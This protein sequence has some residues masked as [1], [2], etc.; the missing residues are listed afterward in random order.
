MSQATVPIIDAD[1]HVDADLGCL[2]HTDCND[3]NPC[4]IDTCSEAG[5]C[6]NA[7]RPAGASCTTGVCDGAAVEPECVQC[8]DNND[9]PFPDA[10]CSFDEPICTGGASPVCVEC[11]VPGHCT[12]SGQ[13]SEASCS[14]N[15]CEYTSLELG[16]LC[17][18][19]VCDG[20]PTSPEC[21]NCVD[22]D[23]GGGIDAGCTA[24]AR[25]C[26]DTLPAPLCRTCGP[27]ALIDDAATPP[28]SEYYDEPVLLIEGGGAVNPADP[29]YRRTLPSWLNWPVD[30]ALPEV[31]RRDLEWGA[32]NLFVQNVYANN[33][34][35]PVDVVSLTSLT[36]A[37]ADLETAP[38][39]FAGLEQA[40]LDAIAD[41]EDWSG[42]TTE[43]GVAI[44]F[45]CSPVL[46]SD[47]GAPYADYSQGT[48]YWV[49]DDTLGEQLEGYRDLMFY[50]GTYDP[51]EPTGQGGVDYGTLNDAIDATY[52]DA[53]GRPVDRPDLQLWS[54]AWSAG[55]FA[56]LEALDLGIRIA[57]GD[58]PTFCVDFVL[59]V[60][61]GTIYAPPDAC[62]L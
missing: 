1:A 11:T 27:D 22:S 42:A 30:A 54:N 52:R 34:G 10:G 35:R 32:V 57:R 4:T 43:C 17:I 16:T 55:A 20:E 40:I 8:A 50:T 45:A 38:H 13:C 60:C 6:S 33:A 49:T 31:D 41:E 44:D 51:D 24:G 62:P 26:D 61:G 39:T 14:D 3:E 19:G 56:H 23:P 46:S 53:F 37:F 7:S 58:E 25:L 5:E 47:P 9:L 59:D 18:G 29:L 36:T 21:V 48:V 12:D 15:V 2:F 28:Y